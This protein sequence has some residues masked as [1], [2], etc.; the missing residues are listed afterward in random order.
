MVAKF[1][2]IENASRL[3]VTEKYYKKNEIEFSTDIK[4]I[5]TTIVKEYTE[6]AH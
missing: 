4:K 2:A 3:I 1:N 6:V 5:I